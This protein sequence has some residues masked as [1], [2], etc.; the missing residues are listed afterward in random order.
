MWFAWLARN[1]SLFND[2]N[3]QAE[4]RVDLVKYKLWTWLK[5]KDPSFTYPLSCLYA[6]PNRCLNLY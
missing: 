5:A 6:N 3:I 2:L 1:N 4:E